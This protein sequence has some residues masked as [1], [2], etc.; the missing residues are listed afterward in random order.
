MIINTPALA[1]RDVRVFPPL[2]EAQLTDTLRVLEDAIPKWTA[3]HV[4]SGGSSKKGPSPEQIRDRLL[5]E[6]QPMLL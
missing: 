3:V 2:F 5:K 1:V 4:L 6:L